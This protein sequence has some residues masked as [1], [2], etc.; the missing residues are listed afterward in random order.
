VGEARRVGLLRAYSTR[1]GAGPFVAEEGR[2]GELLPEAHNLPNP[3][4]GPMRAGPFDV[5]A[6]RYGVE[7]CGGVDRLALSCLDRL[8]GAGPLRVCVAYRYEGED[9]ADLDAFFEV[10]RRAAE[11]LIRRIKVPPL[12]AREHQTELAARLLRCRPVY[13]ELEGFRQARGPAQG[14]S[15]EAR[16]Y[17]QFLEEE[18]GAEVGLVS[19]GPTAEDKLWWAEP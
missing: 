9:D 7:I 6:A 2:M 13:R 1:H 3:W 16:A 19:L 12:A 17:V 5:V 4:Q 8:E 14:L 11:L 18:V 10:E 15:P